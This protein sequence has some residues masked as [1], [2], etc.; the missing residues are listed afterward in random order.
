MTFAAE[1]GQG[2]PARRDFI[3]AK[4]VTA[5]AGVPAISDGRNRSHKVRSPTGGR[6]LAY[7]VDTHGGLP[8]PGSANSNVSH[9]PSSLYASPLH[10]PYEAKEVDF[11][12][13][14]KM[15]LAQMDRKR[16]QQKQKQHRHRSSDQSCSPRAGSP[17]TS[18]RRPPTSVRSRSPGSQSPG[19]R[20]SRNQSF[21]KAI[22]KGKGKDGV[23]LADEEDLS[24]VSPATPAKHPLYTPAEV[25]TDRRRGRDPQR[26]TESIPMDSYDTN[27]RFR[28]SGIE[29]TPVGMRSPDS[30]PRRSYYSPSSTDSRPPVEGRDSLGRYKSSQPHLDPQICQRVKTPDRQNGN[31]LPSGDQR[32]DL[33]PL[34][35]RNVQRPDGQSPENNHVEDPNAN[36]PSSVDGLSP[37]L[38]KATLFGENSSHAPSMAS[39]ATMEDYEYDDYMPSLPGSYFTMDPH[40]YTLT[41]SQQQPWAQKRVPNSSSETSTTPVNNESNA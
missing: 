29:D 9:T 26:Y 39:L 10:S 36:T 8:R 19:S 5:H 33:K 34:P 24:P 27:K 32:P 3:I 22:T 1:T 28:D 37:I 11:V 13:D 4:G 2:H 7:N 25:N 21:K 18:H 6:E 16:H 17:E 35:L 41:W 30:D 31:F 14:P 23:P 12:H 15:L 40:A 38:K 20:D